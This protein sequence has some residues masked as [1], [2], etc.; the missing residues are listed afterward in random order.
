MSNLK[1]IH[2]NRGKHL[3]QKDVFGFPTDVVDNFV[4]KPGT[5]SGILRH[6]DKFHTLPYDEAKKSHD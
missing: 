4:G 6:C 1:K 5:D 3:L 2:V